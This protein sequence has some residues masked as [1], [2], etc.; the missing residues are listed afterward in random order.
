MAGEERE[1][2]DRVRALA[3]ALLAQASR[4]EFFTLVPLL[5]RLTPSAVRVGSDGPPQAE[6]LRFR[7][8]PSMGFS[9]SDISSAKLG[10]RRKRGPADAPD[11]RIAIELTTTF[12]G[13]SGAA[14]PLPLY[15]P[16]EV[17]QD[18]A[19]HNLQARFL[20]IFHHR[21]LSLF[22]RL[23]VRYSCESEFSSDAEDAWSRRIATL[24]SPAHVGRE[25]RSRIPRAKLLKLAPL[26]FARARTARSLEL[27]L[28]DTLEL[29]QGHVRVRH[30]VGGFVALDEAERMRL[31]RRTAVLGKSSVLGS[32]IYAPA[33]RFAIELG[34][35]AAGEYP[36]YVDRGE[37]AELVREVVE[38]LVREPLDYDVELLL[39]EDALPG[40]PLRAR[41]GAMLGVATRLRSTGHKQHITLKNFGKRVLA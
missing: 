37:R 39:G 29:P 23:F 32:H 27:A 8:D 9:A 33:A 28:E 19:G 12:L 17:A 5:E 26:L 13:L 21:L 36:R 22:Y 40:F 2:A 3:E 20:D 31:A 41:T 16:A 1:P 34:P 18:N 38:L 6:A 7:H 35:V 4:S 25:R 10:E 30:F 14:S 15:I 24:A 11:A